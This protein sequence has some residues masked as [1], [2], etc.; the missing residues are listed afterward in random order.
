MI[1]M[2]LG[3]LEEPERSKLEKKIEEHC[4]E[5]LRGVQRA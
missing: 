4:P 2:L 3:L 1:A 5:C